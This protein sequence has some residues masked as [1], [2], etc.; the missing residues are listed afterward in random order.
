MSCGVGTTLK[1]DNANL[2]H[3]ATEVFSLSLSLS[4]SS[5]S[6]GMRCSATLSVH[7]RDSTRRQLTVL[8]LD[9]LFLPHVSTCA[10]QLHCIHAHRKAPFL[11]LGNISNPSL[12]FPVS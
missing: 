8:C 7:A 6:A 2:A 5:L 4:L 9:M 1:P 3:K 10:F 11:I 12:Q